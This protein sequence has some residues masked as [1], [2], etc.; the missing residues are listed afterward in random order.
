MTTLAHSNV[1]LNR[2]SIN[3]Y[4]WKVEIMVNNMPIFDEV[5]R[6]FGTLI[7][8]FEGGKK[9]IFLKCRDGVIIDL[10]NVQRF[11]EQLKRMDV[12]EEQINKGLKF[13]NEKMLGFS[14]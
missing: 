10:P 14:V 4:I 8:R 12:P 5:D 1:L 3:I 7:F 9:R 6:L 13:F 2:G 11:V